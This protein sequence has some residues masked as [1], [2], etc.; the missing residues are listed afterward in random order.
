MT[1]IINFRAGRY[2]ISFHIL[3][4]LMTEKYENNATQVPSSDDTLLGVI[5]YQKVPTPIYDL[6][7]IL[8][9][10]SAQQQMSDLIDLLH[11][12]EKDHVEWLNALQSSIETGTEFTKARDPHQCA[13]GK[14]YDSF[15]SE[16]EDLKHILQKFDEPH[17][18]IHSL[19]DKLL[20]MAATEGKEQALKVLNQQR[21]STLRLLLN[22]FS[23]A[24]EAVSSSYK[25]VIV[26][27]TLNGATPSLGFLVDSVDDA[28]T[29]DESDIQSFVNDQAIKFAG[30]LN[31]PRMISGLI[32]KDDVNSLLIDPS[33]IDASLPEAYENEASLA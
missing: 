22:L 3:H 21:K 9:G 4:I 1:E 18:V 24:R 15:K 31:L 19:A 32:T 28:L 16:N 2:K 6:T 33:L 29:I 26:Y 20:K 13:F 27:T 25:P 5:N 8:E 30:E 12:R 17:K 23:A 14:W 7:R 11:E 10:S